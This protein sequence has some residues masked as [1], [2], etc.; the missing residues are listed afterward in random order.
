MGP[1]RPR[2]LKSLGALWQKLKCQTEGTKFPKKL[3]SSTIL[4]YFFVLNTNLTS[5]SC[6]FLGILFKNPFFAIF[7]V[8]MSFLAV[9]FTKSL[10]DT[11]KRLSGSPN[12][13]WASPRVPYRNFSPWFIGACHILATS[14]AQRRFLGYFLANFGFSKAIFGT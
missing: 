11:K 5:I 2:G 3:W 4:T 12:F 13:F 6:Y 7:R 1:R 9:H 8:K 14:Q 10:F